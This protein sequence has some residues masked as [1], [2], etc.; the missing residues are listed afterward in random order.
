MGQNGLTSLTY[1][2]QSFLYGPN[3]APYFV[4]V[5]QT[6][7][8]GNSTSMANSPSNTVVNPV[9]N[10]ITQTFN[11]G[12]SVV[13]YQASG[14]KLIMTVSLTNTLSNPITRYWMFPLG[15]QLPATPLNF[16][17][18]RAFSIDAP[19]D[20]FFDYGSGTVDLVDEDIVNPMA[21]ML[22]QAT[23]PPGPAWLMSLY[24]DPGSNLNPNWPAI[25]RPIAPGG[26]DTITISLRFGAAG[27]TEPQLAGDL[28]ARFAAAFPRLLPAAA[29][30]K[31]IA[32]LTFTGKFRPFLPKNP[33]GWLNDP[34]IDVTT[35]AGIASFQKKLLAAADTAIAEMTRVGARGGIIWDI[36]GQEYDLAFY[37]DPA[38]AETLA[39]ELV[40]V[41]DQFVAK[42]RN[43]GLQIGF[44]VEPRIFTVTS[45][46]VNVSGT[47]VT[48]TGGTQFSS[49]WAGQVG[50]GEIT[51]G[52][53]NYWIA[54][55]QSPTSLTLQTPAP[56]MSNAPYSY[57]L[58]AD[59]PTP[60]AV[61][62]QKVAY[63]NNRFGATLFYCDK[64]L[65]FGGTLVTPA[66]AFEDIT[67][68]FPGILFFPEWAGARHYAYTYPFL[69]STNGITEP[70]ASVTWVYPQAAGLVR[71]PNDQNIQAAVPALIQSV[72]TGNIL[73]FDGWYYHSG[74]DTVIQIYQQAP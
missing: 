40:G 24:V 10:T 68:Q 29:P 60:E 23:N 28:Y 44:D 50:G 19:A 21:M 51:L 55:V 54:S 12:T 63:T 27:M 35:P 53:N 26:S 18:P 3:V 70:A 36:E 2:G 73:L 5:F 43:A 17:N 8:S 4:N 46:T 56:N 20:V 30:R 37:G 71:V 6:D 1:N 57:P 58:E 32:R 61:L 22:W 13:Q 31:P 69:D 7:S 34:T 11:W 45:G 39:P 42:F 48:W 64:D 41:L 33:R 52:N 47:Q 49:A 62:Q 25:N 74:N 72:S 14:N 15:V 67:Q 9:A 59:S 65:T 66:Q 38:Q 16:S